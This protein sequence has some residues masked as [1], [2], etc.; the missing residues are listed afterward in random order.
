MPAPL[1]AL[2]LTASAAQGPIR[3]A[4]PAWTA[5][6]VSPQE[7]EFYSEHLSQQL[8]GRGLAVTTAKQIETLLGMERQRAVAG[9]NDD[10][11]GSCMTELANALGADAIVSG[12][13]GKLE[14][15]FQLN[16]KVLSARDGHAISVYT[17]RV[18]GRGALI[19]E[20]TLAG[21]KFAEDLARAF[22]RM[23]PPPSDLVLA[24]EQTAQ[25]P[26]K[27]SAWVPL[28][29]GIAAA[30]GAGVLAFESN[31]RATALQATSGTIGYADARRLRDEGALFQTL[32]YVSAG[33][34][35]VGLAGAATM[36]WYHKPEP[37][38]EVAVGASPA[39][40]FVSLGGTFP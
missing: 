6:N 35:V 2:L 40:A 17:A 27:A 20:L 19:D 14:D 32:S 3:V 21:H 25:Q 13:L 12:E 1:L 16:L 28:A 18:G 4:A 31:Q 10:S 34:A 5:A 29:V 26:L 23:L 7:A 8:A 11:S 30:G 15:G 36:F 39:G 22:H 37:Q 38:L 9:C 33:V 24:A